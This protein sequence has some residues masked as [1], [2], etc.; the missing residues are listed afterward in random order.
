MRFVVVVVGDGNEGGG[1][2]RVGRDARRVCCRRASFSTVMGI[3]R[4]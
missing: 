1:E 4:V 2:G 3:V